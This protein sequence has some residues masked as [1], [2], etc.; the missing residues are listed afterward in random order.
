M[1][2]RPHAPHMFSENEMRLQVAQLLPRLLLNRQRYGRYLDILVTHSPPYGIHDQ[3][4]LP[5]TGFKVFLTFMS[6]FKPRF[7]LHG[8]VHL[9]R[10]DIPRVTP[11]E[12]TTVI[13]VYPYRILDT[14]DPTASLT[15]P[16]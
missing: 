1:R 9:Y 11:Y 7:L 2:Y 10:Q 5:H 16:V 3:P 8:H 14:E 6:L 13:N 12:D 15:P 4:D